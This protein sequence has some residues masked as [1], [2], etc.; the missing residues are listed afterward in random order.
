[1]QLPQQAKVIMHVGR[2]TSQ[3]NHA[4][5]IDLFKYI[6]NYDNSILLCLA[7][8]GELRQEVERK[9]EELGLRNSV[10]FL[11]VR[12]DIPQ[13]LLSIAHVFVFPSLHEG[14][15][16]SVIEAQAAGVSCVISDR[17]PEIM[18][19]VDSLVTRLSL[20]D[21]KGIWRNAVLAAMEKPKLD[22]DLVLSQIENSMFNIRQNAKT[23][24]RIYFGNN[25]TRYL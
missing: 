18:I 5:L 10:R 3:K 13:L 8:D 21:S 16:V 17:I 4:F 7:G 2:F 24:S 14:A 12:K 22:H 11:G 19:V 9:V 25:S 1:L 6:H 15:P 20:D 23:L